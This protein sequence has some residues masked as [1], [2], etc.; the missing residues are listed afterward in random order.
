MH[1]TNALKRNNDESENK[2]KGNRSWKWKHILKPISD[3]KELYTGK[4]L[5]SSVD[6]TSLPPKEAFYSN[7]TDEG[8]T[9]EDY[10]HAHTV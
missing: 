9:D 3:E 8:I 10:Q 6:E 5:N 4:G 7:L 2:P 1:S